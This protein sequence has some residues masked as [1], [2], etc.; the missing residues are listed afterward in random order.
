M[1]PDPTQPHIRTATID[2]YEKK[3][4][5][6]CVYDMLNCR[7]DVLLIIQHWCIELKT[8]DTSYRLF[9]SLLL[10][11]YLIMPWSYIHG[12]VNCEGYPKPLVK[13]EEH[14]AENSG[15]S[16]IKSHKHTIHTSI[17]NSRAYALKNKGI[18]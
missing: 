14:E 9:L 2:F 17:W 16:D 11:K 1:S 4:I 13:I 5:E 7:F 6:P 18:P 8:C 12:E 3:V 15:E 10:Q